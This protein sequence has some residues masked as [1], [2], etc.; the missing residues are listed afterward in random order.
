LVRDYVQRF[1]LSDGARVL[2]PFCGTGTTLVEAKKLG[3]ASVGV[4]A[5]PI[6]HLAT[7]TKVDWACRAE[8]LRKHARSVA[9]VASQRTQAGLRAGRTLRTL[10]AEAYALLLKDSISPLPLHRTLVLLDVIKEHYTPEVHSQELL[11]LAKVLPTEVGNVRFGP[12][13]G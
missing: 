10:P 13:V 9:S 7:S 4:E 1:D 2:D 5:T 8:M 11:A 12:E 6:G 3:I